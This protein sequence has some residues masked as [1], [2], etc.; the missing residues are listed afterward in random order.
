MSPQ[1]G[2]F[3]ML[4]GK[5]EERALKR[6]KS[7]GQGGNDAQLLMCLVVKVKARVSIVKLRVRRVR[8]SYS[9]EMTSKVSARREN[10]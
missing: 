6:M 3:N 9:E 2:R 8:K 1:V 7:L 5:G 10:L 4:V